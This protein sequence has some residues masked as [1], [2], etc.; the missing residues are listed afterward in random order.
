[1]KTM[2]IREKSRGKKTKVNAQKTYRDSDG[3]WVAVIDKVEFIQACTYVC[4]G[5]DNCSWEK[6][7]VQVDLDDDGKNYKV[8]TH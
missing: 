6:L 4:Q 8:V 1:M 5:I 3:D 2:T 7:D